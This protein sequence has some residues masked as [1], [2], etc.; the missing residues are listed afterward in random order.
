[1]LEW[2]GWQQVAMEKGQIFIFHFFTVFPA[3][4]S[5]TDERMQLMQESRVNREI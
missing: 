4:L 5:T 3:G 2:I 1:V